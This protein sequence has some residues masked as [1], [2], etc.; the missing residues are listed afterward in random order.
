AKVC[1]TMESASKIANCTGMSAV[2]T[3]ACASRC[4]FRPN[5][6][7]FGSL[8]RT[9]G[10]E[11]GRHA[12]STPREKPAEQPQRVEPEPGDEDALEERQAAFERGRDVHAAQPRVR[13]EPGSEPPHGA[14]QPAPPDQGGRH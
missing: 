7:F 3:I 12:G 14:G 13:A 1:R 2:T 5:T 10:G 8:P 11:Q 4:R 9:V 6:A